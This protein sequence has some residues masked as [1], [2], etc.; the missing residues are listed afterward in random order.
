MCVCVGGGGGSEKKAN[1]FSQKCGLFRFLRRCEMG[2]F[3][4]S[5]SGK[6]DEGSVLKSVYGDLRK[7]FLGTLY[8][9]T[10]QNKSGGRA[11]PISGRGL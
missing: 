10:S 4:T 8:R 9:K 1:I 11:N 6:N 2:G 7:K 5:T 3:L